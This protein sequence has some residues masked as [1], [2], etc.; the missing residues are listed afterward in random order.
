M[1]TILYIT[2]VFLIMMTCNCCGPSAEEKAAMQKAEQDE[3]A[4]SPPTHSWVKIW[5]Q[6]GVEDTLEVTH[7]YPIAMTSE[8]R[9]YEDTPG[10][11]GGRTIATNISAFSV[12][13]T[14]VEP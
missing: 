2:V 9:L 14:E 11:C 6:T 8:G 10:C 5:F 3:A 7:K 4:L 13:K 12:F 1:K